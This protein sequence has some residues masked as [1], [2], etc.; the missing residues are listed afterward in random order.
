MTN[1]VRDDII[2]GGTRT[3]YVGPVEM[4]YERAREE[5]SKAR[6]GQEVTE[7]SPITW[8]TESGDSGILRPGGTVKVE[9]GLQL[10]V[11]PGHLS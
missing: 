7:G 4:T 5:W 10:K 6:D 3:K 1:E 11:D 9:D 8:R 2:I